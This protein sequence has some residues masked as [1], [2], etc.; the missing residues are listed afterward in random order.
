MGECRDRNW[1]APHRLRANI[2]DKQGAVEYDPSPEQCK[3]LC[4]FFSK[5]AA[6]HFALASQ[7]TKGECMLS[8]TGL[9]QTALSA[10]IGIDFYVVR[11]LGLHV[12]LFPI[13]GDPAGTDDFTGV[14]GSNGICYRKIGC[15]C[16]CARAHTTR[17]RFVVAC[18]HR[19]ERRAV[20]QQDASTHS[21]GTGS[22][23]HPFYRTL[24]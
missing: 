18:G 7:G 10:L 13:G 15:K 14:G 16:V 20:L 1:K 5:C 12:N 4:G 3:A 6:Y 21:W 24:P 23:I 9:Y 17:N 19:L 8:G 11:A 22:T 2:V